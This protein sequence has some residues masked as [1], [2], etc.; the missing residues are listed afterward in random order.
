MYLFC[1]PPLAGDLESCYDSTVL[2]I[3]VFKFVAN[4]KALSLESFNGDILRS[5]LWTAVGDLQ[6][7]VGECDVCYQ[8][9]YIA[10][11]LV[12]C[13]RGSSFRSW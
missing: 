9:G 1:G 7:I 5:D 4:A 6:S 12:D 3:F 2:A 11:R 13:C 8:W 10:E